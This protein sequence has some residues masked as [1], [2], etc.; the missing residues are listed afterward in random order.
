MREGEGKGRERGKGEREEREYHKG[1]ECCIEG[2]EGHEGKM[3]VKTSVS[4]GKRH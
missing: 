1:K 4:E 3:R 2:K